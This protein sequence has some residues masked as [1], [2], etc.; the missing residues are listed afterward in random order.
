MNLLNWRIGGKMSKRKDM[1]NYIKK[2]KKKL[3]KR[4]PGVSGF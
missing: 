3:R 1:E 2:N 4:Y